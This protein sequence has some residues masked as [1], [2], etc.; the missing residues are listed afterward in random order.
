MGRAE[1]NHNV[2]ET[3][4]RALAINSTGE[5]FAGTAGA[6]KMAFTVRLTTATAGR[7]RTQA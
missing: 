1:I 5:M 7:L 6:V 3:D 2:I 4:V